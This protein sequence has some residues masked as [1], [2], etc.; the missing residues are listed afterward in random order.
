VG[1]VK[2]LGKLVAGIGCVLR[3]RQKFDLNSLKGKKFQAV[4][5]HR[6]D[7]KTDRTYANIGSIIKSKSRVTL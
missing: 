5:E 1:S 7:P 4:I 6:Y 3:D 2:K